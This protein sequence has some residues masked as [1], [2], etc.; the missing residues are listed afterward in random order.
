MIEP[1]YCPN[2]SKRTEPIIPLLSLNGAGLGLI[3]E[4]E[5]GLTGKPETDCARIEE[6]VS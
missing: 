4:P 2:A 6:I 5:D 1:F 3:F